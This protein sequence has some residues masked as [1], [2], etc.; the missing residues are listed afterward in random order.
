M[1]ARCFPSLFTRYGEAIFWH[2]GELQRVLYN[3]IWFFW[4]FVRSE[5]FGGVFW[6]RANQHRSPRE[7]KMV[8]RAVLNELVKSYDREGAWAKLEAIY[9]AA[10]STGDLSHSHRNIRVRYGSDKAVQDVEADLKRLCGEPI[11]PYELEDTNERC[12]EAITEAC[13]AAF[14]E[15][16]T[17]KVQDSVQLASKDTKRFLFLLYREG[18]ILSGQIQTVEESVLSRF[19]PA[20]KVVFGEIEGEEHKVL[21]VALEE[22]IKAGM[23]YE[24]YRSTARRKDYYYLTVPSFAKQVWLELPAAIAFPILNVTE[25]WR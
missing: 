22:M 10:M 8:T 19:V 6:L 13:E 24:W 7:Q 15:F 25:V 14:P 5:T 16:I 12:R 20:Y 11:V 3:K 17:R 9:L 18:T 2:V 1:Q 23:V 21:T 4:G